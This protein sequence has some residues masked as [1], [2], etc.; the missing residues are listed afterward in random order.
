MVYPTNAFDSRL[1]GDQV[2]LGSS[3]TKS[4]KKKKD[5]ELVAHFRTSLQHDQH[6]GLGLRC[7]RCYARRLGNSRRSAHAKAQAALEPGLRQ[8]SHAI[9]WPLRPPFLSFSLPPSLLEVINIT[10]ENRKASNQSAELNQ[11]LPDLY[12][13]ICRFSG[14]VHFEQPHAQSLFLFPIVLV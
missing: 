8:T 5:I 6:Q 1:R 14:G 2:P 4:H 9:V 7:V 11:C 12:F 10:V 13:A 3:P